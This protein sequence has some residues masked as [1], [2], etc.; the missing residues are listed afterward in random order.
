MMRGLRPLVGLA[1]AV[2]AAQAGAQ[3][4]VEVP[5]PP[6]YQQQPPG[7]QPPSP[8]PEGQPPPPGDCCAVV[9]PPK[10]REPGDVLVSISVGPTYRRAFR[11]DFFAAGLE[12]EIG[13]QTR[14]F[15]V[16]GRAQLDLGATRVGLP[17]QFATFGPS[18]WFRVSPRVRAGFGVGFGIF[19][20][21]RASSYASTDPTV[22]APSIGADVAATID[23]VRSRRGGALYLLGRAAYDWIDNFGGDDQFSTG[24]SI[25]L[26]AALGYRY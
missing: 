1:V 20:Y 15:G 11:E 4:M 23:L 10:P 19:S 21:Q 24:S 13:G 18:F 3:E 25:A 8:P 26:T 2:C 14:S 22:W 7:G 17:Y 9:E 16:A 5:T 6:Q 12:F